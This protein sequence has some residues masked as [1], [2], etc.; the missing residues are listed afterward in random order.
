MRIAPR[1]KKK[2][3]LHLKWSNGINAK[4]PRK[5]EGPRKFQ[6]FFPVQNPIPE[7]GLEN[8]DEEIY[9]YLAT[10]NQTKQD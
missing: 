10:S 3:N 1:K 5:E 8:E 9:L 4:T 2:T 6:E 7:R